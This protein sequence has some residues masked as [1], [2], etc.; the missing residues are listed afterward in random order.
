[1]RILHV[2]AK[3]QYRGAER[4]AL[5]LA[6]ELESLGHRNRVLALGP[7]AD[8]SVEADLPVLLA[9]PGEGPRVL[10]SAVREVRR[11]LRRDR[12]D[13][14][15]AHGGWPVQVA[16]LARG[17][18]GPRVVWQRILGFPPDMWRAARRR[19][20]R[21]IAR[22]TDAAVALTTDLAE[23]LRRLGFVGPVRVIANTRRPDRFLAV[24]R[25]EAQAALRAEIGVDASVP[26]LGFVGHLV[27]QK[28]PERAVEV[29][30]RVR[31]LG[32][33][34]HLV[35]VGDGPLR[36]LVERAARERA[37]TDHVTLLGHR[38]D[39]EQVFGAL[40]LVLITS[41][42]EGI[43]G[44]AIEAQMAGCPVVT[45]PLGGV[46]EVVDHGQ[47]GIVL[48][49]FDTDLMAEYAVQLLRSPEMRRSFGA[50]ARGRA[51]H[52]ATERA[53]REYEDLFSGLLA[54]RRSGNGSA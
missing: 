51:H 25:R 29:L 53:A 7:A 33:G 17:G 49:R 2:V 9:R 8:G 11:L 34:A 50:R 16:A 3:S 30:Q 44:V 28:R 18:R 1:M 39:V 54:R 22:R 31:A 5:E 47:T 40:D 27:R 48:D 46:G 14:L 6:H 37:L 19:Y 52:F 23:E 10:P 12:P 15:L 32:A 43:P 21:T 41:D 20:W 26:L 42:S 13:I 36:P 35:V 45:F 38:R 24:D 4:A